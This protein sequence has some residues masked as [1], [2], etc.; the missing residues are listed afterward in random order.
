MS[1]E[2]NL[3]RLAMSGDREAQRLV[4]ESL[5]DP[6]GRLVSRV[7]GS[8]D[9]DDVTQDVFLRLFR[10]LGSFRFESQFA[11]WVYRLTINHAFQH[12]RH[13]H[14]RPCRPLDGVDVAEDPSSSCFDNHE[15]LTVALSRLEPE[16][17]LLLH[18]KEEQNESYARI[19]EIL[20]IPEGTVGSRLNRARKELRDA[21]L[22]LGWGE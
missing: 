21:L 2:D 15:V 1:L 12:L 9:A 4:Y 16:L 3:I 10:S 18:L 6:V 5:K 13:E 20:G 14:R 7:V 22:S 11:T 8:S 19:A 17:R